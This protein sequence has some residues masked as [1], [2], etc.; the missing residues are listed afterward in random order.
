MFSYH[1]PR[2]LSPLASSVRRLLRANLSDLPA[3]FS[4]WVPARLLSATLPGIRRR[5]LTR[6][7]IFWAFLSQVLTRSQTCR[8]TVRK[9]QGLAHLYRRSPLSSN[10]S[11][12]CQA[13]TKLPDTLL[14]HIHAQIV[15]VVEH[16]APTALLWR[17][18]HVGVVDGSTLSMPDTPANQSHY[19]QPSEQ[20][21]GCGFPVMKFVGLFSLATG[22]W[23][24]L[25]V[26][27][28]H[29]HD[30]SLFHRLWDELARGFDVVL[31]DRGFTSFADMYCLKQRGVDSV[32]RRHQMRA[33]DF[34]KGKR[35]GRC[36][37]LVAWAKPLQRPAWLSQTAFD[38]M[39]NEWIVREVK[40]QVAIKG[41]RTQTCVIVTTLLDPVLYPPAALAELYFLRW[42]VE[43]HLRDIKVTL[44]LDVLRCRS[45]NMVQKELWMH[46]IAHNLVR[47]LM[48]K[49]A[50]HY[51]LA[52][53]RL[54]FKGAV[55][56]IRQWAPILSMAAHH[57]LRYAY[58]FRHLLACLAH[59]LVPLRPH[60]AEPRTKKRRPKNYQLLTRPRHRMGNLSHRNKPLQKRKLHD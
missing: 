10:T 28:L 49:T 6:P 26:G 11:A 55:D 30:R 34:R 47:A 60:R 48:L 23:H 37:H 7:V 12:Y 51:R 13:R 59:D 9:L 19:P 44:G 25:A 33:T 38:A 32:F 27:N 58:L 20:K 46:V 15:S 4:A 2:C 8:E 3:L 56:I 24:A 57:P 52:L 40:I 41:F 35:L 5:H 54:S 21:T 16:Q 1:R 50:L 22:L 29:D 39:L 43:L 14:K 31:G 53:D 36:D 17:N 45:P 42:S 18:R